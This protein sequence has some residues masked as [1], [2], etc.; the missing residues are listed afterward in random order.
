MEWNGVEDESGQA[1]G[2]AIVLLWAGED[3]NLVQAV[4]VD[5]SGWLGEMGLGDCW[6]KLPRSPEMF[7]LSP[8]SL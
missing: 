6:D 1:S 7:L 5:R 3:G 2:E 4:T 8:F